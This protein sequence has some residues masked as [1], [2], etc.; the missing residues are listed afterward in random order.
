MKKSRLDQSAMIKQQIELLHSRNS[1]DFQTLSRQVAAKQKI[2]TY[3]PM[4]FLFSMFIDSPTHD[5]I[6]G[7]CGRGAGKT[8]V[9]GD[10]IRKGIT[11]MPRAKGIMIGLT[12]KSMD[13]LSLPS[14]KYALELQGIYE[15]LHYFEGRRPP[16][17]WKWPKP[18]Q[19]PKE[20]NRIWTFYTG[21][22]IQMISLDASGEG[23]GPNVHFRLADEFALLDGFKVANID[24]T[25]RAPF[26]DTF[27]KNTPLYLN[28]IAT[29]T[30]PLD[31]HGAH[32]LDREDAAR[33]NPTTN[34]FLRATY[35]VNRANLPENYG[36][37]ARMNAP[38]L[39]QYLAEYENI[40]PTK[41]QN[42]F[43]AQ[44]NKSK[45]TYTAYAYDNIKPDKDS[46]CLIDA[47]WNPDLPLIL[48]LDWGAAINCMVILQRDDKAREVRA[49]KEFFAKSDDG[50]MQDDMVEEF[51]HYYK[52]HPTKV[53]YM[54]YD[55]TGNNTT[56]NTRMT[57]AAQAAAQLRIAG[58]N[59]QQQTVGGRNPLHYE[60][61]LTWEMI[62]SENDKRV[63][64]FRLN[65][66]NCNNLWISMTN[67][68]AKISG[69][70]KEIGKDKG[71][72][73][74]KKIKRQHATDFGDAIDSPIYTLFFRF[75]RSQAT[76]S[77]PL[78][79]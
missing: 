43:Y 18:Y 33:D 63:P 46:T 74:S 65:I 5:D 60:K 19:A 2:L 52:P 47:D 22:A 40:R 78:N 26:L 1:G 27:Q 30:T 8:T 68:K 23:R 3:N 69:R 6:N 42:A 51:I 62:L 56:G 45:H 77:I 21:F 25:V 70:N 61:Y 44:L 13:E 15:G 58:W 36:E 64:R 57:R 49:I 54:Y 14:L 29:S 48:G 16:A 79:C 72:E 12:F 73:R 17:K 31:Q 75:A 59:V 39:W 4:Q 38:F 11:Q 10:F 20:Y 50:K 24:A 41:V 34:A 66:G 76:V 67:T 7:E 28:K 55:N 71:S 9:L 32:F 35:R 53:V 37:K